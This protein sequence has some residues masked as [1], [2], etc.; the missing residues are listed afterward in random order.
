MLSDKIIYKQHFY[1][2]WLKI[3]KGQERFLKRETVWE[4]VIGKKHKSKIIKI[5]KLT[6][7]EFDL[8]T[9]ARFVNWASQNIEEKNVEEIFNNPS[10]VSHVCIL[11]VKAA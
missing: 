8:L 11:C 2:I 6:E 9:I 3:R 7:H 1:K 10:F 4:D 5:G